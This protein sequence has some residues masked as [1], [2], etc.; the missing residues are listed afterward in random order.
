MNNLNIPR[1][2]FNFNHK[3]IELHIFTDA[4]E[5]AY[6]ACVYV[7]CLNNDGT[8]TVHLLTSK[9]K[10]A[11]IKHLTIP[12]LELCGALLGARLCAKVVASLAIKINK[13]YYWCDSTIVL[14]WLSVSPNKLQPFVRNRVSEIQ[15]STGE[16]SWRYVSSKEN[17]ADLVS[18]GLRA[19]QIGTCKLWWS[20][21]EFLKLGEDRW[22][23]M[24]NTGSNSDIPEFKVH[25]VDNCQ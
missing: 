4:S 12:R 17:P 2:A 15:E 19:D 11:P 20:G 24:P 22:P 9:N 13:V 23:K 21:P 8:T 25:L 18:R 14:C 6:G 1:H 5:S 7:R 10:V 16:N 3:S